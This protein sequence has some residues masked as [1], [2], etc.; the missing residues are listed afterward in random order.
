M[1]TAFAGRRVAIDLLPSPL[2][3]LPLSLHSLGCPGT[4]YITQAGRMLA[5]ITCLCLP[6]VLGI[7]ACT[8]TLGPDGLFLLIFLCSFPPANINMEQ[9][10]RNIWLVR[11]TV[12]YWV[13]KKLRYPES[14]LLW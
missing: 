11:A 10:L 2:P 9:E 13:S 8:T 4:H 12:R 6:R 7:K 14:R 5:E 1:G 3:C